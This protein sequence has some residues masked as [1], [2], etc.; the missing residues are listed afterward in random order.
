MTMKILNNLSP[1]QEYSRS[2]RLL[3]TRRNAVSCTRYERGTIR[4]RILCT[5]IAI[6]VVVRCLTVLIRLLK[7]LNSIL[8]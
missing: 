6:H 7:H 8:V 3:H 5:G 4:S 1:G 2:I